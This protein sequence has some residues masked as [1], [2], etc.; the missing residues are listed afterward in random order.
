M[1]K[2]AL[3]SA[4][5]QFL[6]SDRGSIDPR[7]IVGSIVCLASETVLKG[8]TNF[9]YDSQGASGLGGRRRLVCCADLKGERQDESL[10][11]IDCGSVRDDY[12]CEPS[13]LVDAV[14][15]T[16]YGRARMEAVPGSAGIY[17]LHR[18][19]NLDDAAFGLVH[20]P[21]WSPRIHVRCRAALWGRL[22]P[23]ATNNC[24]WYDGKRRY[25]FLTCNG[26]WHP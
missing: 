2:A 21:V 23:C 19:R 3:V 4:R 15:K 25:G 24:I 22:K 9:E 8:G 17:A 7:Q 16:D 12:D 13:I 11:S 14:C 1:V 18:L 10:E 6:R 26:R 20:R 5:L